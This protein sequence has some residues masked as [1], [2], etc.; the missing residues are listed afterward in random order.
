MKNN[1]FKVGFPYILAS[2]GE[3]LNR[4]VPPPVQDSLAQLLC[5]A[6]ET[7]SAFWGMISKAPVDKPVKL[8]A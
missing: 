7:I 5:G 6:N 3:L 2:V 1:D 4:Y 8:T